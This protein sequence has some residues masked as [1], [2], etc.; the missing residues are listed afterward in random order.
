MRVRSLSWCT[1]IALVLL[2]ATAV[3]QDGGY[4]VL[5]YAWGLESP[6]G[7]TLDPDGH[8]VATLAGSGDGYMDARIVRFQDLNGD[9]MAANGAEQQDLVNGLPTSS[10]APFGEGARFATSDAQVTADGEVY[11][12]T[13]ILVADWAQTGR[14]ALW[15][16][17]APHVGSNPLRI[18]SPYAHFVPYEIAHNVDG[19]ELDSNPFALVL[20]AERNAY[21]TD[22]AANAVYRV[23][24]AGDIMTYAVFPDIS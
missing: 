23:T 13:N 4:E 17:A 6:R 12:V 14:S 3:G 9:G 24:P 7:L 22:A 8:L 18:A 10:F 19:E 16:T 5:P 15:S 20:D 1:L 11:F 21:V 2:P